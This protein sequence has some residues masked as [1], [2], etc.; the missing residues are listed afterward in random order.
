MC[1]D[2]WPQGNPQTLQT[3]ASLTAG[4]SPHRWAPHSLSNAPNGLVPTCPLP[5]PFSLW[6]SLSLVPHLSTWYHL[7]N[8][9]P[10]PKFLCMGLLCWEH[11]VSWCPMSICLIRNDKNSRGR[12]SVKATGGRQ[13]DTIVD[14][15]EVSLPHTENR[16]LV[17]EEGALSHLV[18]YG[19]G[20]EG[21]KLSWQSV[22]RVRPDLSP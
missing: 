8:Y 12:C 18:L 11:K 13:R 17:G 6:C 21:S 10:A 5:S 20:T 19:L 1:G 2:S 16:N 3:P 22:L 14:A 4:G 7:P 15:S 9:L